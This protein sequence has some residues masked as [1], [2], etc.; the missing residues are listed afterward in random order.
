MKWLI[1]SWLLTSVGVAAQAQSTE[2]GLM[3]EIHLYNYAGVS[4]E[5]LARAQ[6]ETARIYQRIGV[7]LDWRICPLNAGELNENTACDVP[8]MHPQF[9]LRLLPNAVAQQLPIGGDIFGFALLPLNQGF[10]VT[11]SVFAGRVQDIAADDELH[12]AIMGYLIAHE[13]GHLLLSEAGHPAAAGIMHTPWQTKELE[14]I[15]QGVMFFLPEQAKK[16][17]AQIVARALSR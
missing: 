12:R 8:C 4:A 1:G 2:V 11:A 6:R 15:K 10:G 9:T 16:I 17:R 7:A 13:L 14:Q 5:T 3:I